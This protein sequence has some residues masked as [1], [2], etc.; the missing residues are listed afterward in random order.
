MKT[1]HIE[2]IDYEIQWYDGDIWLEPLVDMP[3]WILLWTGG[4]VEL[5]KVW[6]ISDDEMCVDCYPS[7][8]LDHIESF[9]SENLDKFTKIDQS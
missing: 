8:R 1:I 4:D 3:N 6:N 5:C 9:V 7:Y 2:G